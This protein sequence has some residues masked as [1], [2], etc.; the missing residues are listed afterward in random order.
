MPERPNEGPQM[1]EKPTE[2]VNRAWTSVLI[3]E[4]GSKV[5]WLK[6]PNEGNTVQN[7]RLNADVNILKVKVTWLCCPLRGFSLKCLLTETNDSQQSCFYTYCIAEKFLA[8]VFRRLEL[9]AKI[10]LISL[11]FSLCWWFLQFE[12]TSRLIMLPYIFSIEA[13]LEFVID[14]CVVKVPPTHKVGAISAL[15]Y[16]N[17]STQ[18][19]LLVF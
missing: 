18:N 8:T 12:T 15:R 6:F 9:W 13:R 4:A 2:F 5:F 3:W 19:L 7:I 16:C 1:H 17:S 14:L 10:R 11:A